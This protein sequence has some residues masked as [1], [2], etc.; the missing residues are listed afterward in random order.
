MAKNFLVP[1]SLNQQEIQNAVIQL[2]GADPGTPVNG[3]VWINT[4]TWQLKIRLNDTTVTLGRLDQITPPTSNVSLGNHRITGLSDGVAST[5]AATVGQ[6]AA[7]RNSMVW[8]DSVRAATT[9]AGTL[10]SSFASGSAIDGITLATGDRILIK[11]QAAGAENGIYVVNATGAPTRATDADTS[12]EMPS[13][14]VVPV[15]QGTANA[16]TLWILTTNAPITLGTTALAF[17]KIPINGGMTY[18]PGTGLTESPAGTFNIDTAIVARHTVPITVGNGSATTFDITHNFGTR[19]ARAVVWRN[20]SPWD[21]VECE[22]QRPDD[23][24][25]RLVFASAPTTAQYQAIA[26]G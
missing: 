24:T 25:L 18:E 7:S 14:T 21:E 1:I 17:A 12:A 6:V 4:V 2:L 19:A 26:L 5:D 3:Q 8:K 9:A 23:N 20:S 15:D 16:D 13:A 11:D 22:V 10:A